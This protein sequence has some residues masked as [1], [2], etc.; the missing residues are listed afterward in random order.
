MI[1]TYSSF[2]EVGIL[3]SHWAL[4][5]RP[6]RF[7]DRFEEVKEMMDDSKILVQSKPEQTAT[8]FTGPGNTG[9]DESLRKL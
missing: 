1:S 4:K 5:V 8:S 9:E 6:T 2:A 7:A 3:T